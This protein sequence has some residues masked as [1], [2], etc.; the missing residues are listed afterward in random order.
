MLAVHLRRGDFLDPAV[1]RV[2]GVPTPQSMADCVAR[3]VPQPAVAVVF[4][5]SPEDIDL[6]CPKI[7]LSGARS[8][9]SQ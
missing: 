9:L 4:S 2:H 8:S 6:P 3:L 1:R 7:N 5:D